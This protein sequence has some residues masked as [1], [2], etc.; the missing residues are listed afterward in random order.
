MVE[1]DTPPACPAVVVE[2][3]RLLGGMLHQ[4]PEALVAQVQLLQSQAL[5]SL[6]QV[7]GV[8]AGRIQEEPEAQEEQEEEAVD[9]AHLLQARVAPLIQVVVAAVVV[10]ET[11]EQEAPASSSS[12][13]LQVRLLLLM[14]RTPQRPQTEVTRFSL[15][16]RQEHLRSQKEVVVV[17]LRETQEH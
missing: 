5:A 4:E 6:A 9:R 17:V 13:S 8:V 7:V 16:T 14:T 1:P 15:G 3:H 12:A 2:E 10:V 11:V